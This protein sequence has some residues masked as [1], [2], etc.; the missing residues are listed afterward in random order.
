MSANMRFMSENLYDDSILYYTNS[1]FVSDSNSNILSP[2]NCKSIS[3]SS[4]LRTSGATNVPIVGILPEVCS[5]YP[6]ITGFAISRSNL[7]STDKIQVRTYTSDKVFS[8]L[9]TGSDPNDNPGTNQLISNSGDIEVGNIVGWGD[10][11]WG[12]FPWGG[13]YCTDSGN[14]MTDIIVI[15]FNNVTQLAKYFH[16]LLYTPNATK[17]EINRIF[18]GTFISPTYNISHGH[19]ITFQDPAKQFR[20]DGGTL[21]TET[22]FR[23]RQ[24]QFNLSVI[25]ATDRTKFAE[26]FARAGKQ[27]DILVSLYPEDNYQRLEE[28]YTMIGKFT[29]VPVMK[30]RIGGYYKASFTMEEV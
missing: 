21:R 10:Q 29:K 13:V 1:D 27:K 4:I 26:L 12:S 30:E 28:D 5:S 18:I 9:V 8:E 16:I 6:S 20:T 22:K 19:S 2:E 3:R 11:D 14:P 7:E 25:D 23:F 15:W 24:L 17:I